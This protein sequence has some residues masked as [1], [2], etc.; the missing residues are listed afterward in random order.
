MDTATVT[1]Q[2]TVQDVEY[3]RHGA[4]PLL[5]RLFT[6]DGKG[7]F[8][9][10]VEL[11]GGAW[12]NGDRTGEHARHEAL[13]KGGLV[14]AALD[15]RQGREGAYPLGVS[16]INYAIRW[17]K[18]HAKEHKIAADAVAVSGRSSGGHLAMLTALRPKDPRY[19][20]TALPP[21]SPAVDAS[22]RCVAMSWPVINPLS[23]YRHA[24]RAR[25]KGESWAPS[26][27]QN[28]LDFWGGEANMA[29]GSATLILERGEKAALPPALWIQAPN[30][31]MHD[32]RDPDGTFDG[33]E[34]QRFVAAYKK[35]GGAIDLVYYDAPLR[36]TSVQPGSA[37]SQQAFARLV[38]FF[39][40][41]MP[42]AR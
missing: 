38:D 9:A 12:C 1:H 10:V 36:F 13:A 26:I 14:V 15:F 11:H 19:T 39:H 7:P 35:A 6:P 32:Y 41:H 30:D 5:M 24:V 17:L 42:V 40:K 25:D 18:A 27:I 8:P 31:N 4:K 22:V 3:L 29:E 16:D 33:N 20:A 21:G 37:V 34:P 28:H 23:R 2:F